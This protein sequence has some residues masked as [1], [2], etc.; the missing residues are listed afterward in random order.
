MIE[1][2]A[3]GTLSA[4]KLLVESLR[5]NVFNAYS[6]AEGI[7]LAAKHP[8][9]IFLVHSGMS[10]MPPREIV[11]KIREMRPDSVIIGLSTSDNG[12]DGTDHCVSSYE[13]E[14][15]V[16]LIRQIAEERNKLA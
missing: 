9:D 7:E 13:P 10:D 11:S 8:M 6:A 5:H 14:R 16:K 12:I 2:D 4:R 3:P 15:M 1:P